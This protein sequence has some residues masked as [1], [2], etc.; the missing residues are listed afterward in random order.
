MAVLRPDRVIERYADYVALY[1]SA[2]GSGVRAIGDA[3]TTYLHTPGAIE[4]VRAYSPD[5]KIVIGVRNPLQMT[6]SLHAYKLVRQGEDVE[7]FEKAWRLSPERQK[8]RQMPNTTAL[9]DPFQVAYAEM[10]LLGRYVARVFEL[11]PAEQ[12]HIVVFDD[13]VNDPAKVYAGLLSFLGLEHDGRTDFTPENVTSGSSGGLVY[14][15]ASHLPRPVIRVLRKLGVGSSGV[16]SKLSKTENKTPT[17]R[18][19][20]RPEFV[21]EMRTFYRDDVVQLS[22]LLNR[23]LSGWTSS[24]EDKVAQTASTGIDD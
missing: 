9:V 15:I 20:L 10:G 2:L 22:R 7:D 24:A 8:G 5:A 13:V 21:E 16:A 11:F 19:A 1:K 4:A 6:R 17:E 23:D 18:A 12:I 3:S 14:R